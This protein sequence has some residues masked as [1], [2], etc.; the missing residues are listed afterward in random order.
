MRIFKSKWFDKFARKE[1]I[2]DEKLRSAIKRAESGLVDADYG[3]GVIKQR[4]AR[5]NEGKSGGYRSIII[6]HRGDRSFF[7]Y[8]FAKN[9]HDN[10]DE[11]DERDFKDAAVSLL[12]LSDSQLNELVGD[13]KFTEIEYD[14]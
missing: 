13:G 11:N 9:D 7:M 8:G 14:D 2:D 5:P 10:I 6:F 3:G 1:R 12:A 4:I